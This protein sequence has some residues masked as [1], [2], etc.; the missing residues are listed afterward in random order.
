[1][2]KITELKKKK[3]TCKGSGN[4]ERWRMRNETKNDI[5]SFVFKISA[6]DKFLASFISGYS[7]ML[8]LFMEI[9]MLNEHAD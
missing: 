4:D 7:I 1:M 9:N 2:K 6:E 8:W 5:C 3:I